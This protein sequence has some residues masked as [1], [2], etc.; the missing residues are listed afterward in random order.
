MTLQESMTAYVAY[1]EQNTK[2]LQDAVADMPEK[3]A[4]AKRQAVADYIAANPPVESGPVTI[5][6]VTYESLSTA[7]QE[8]NAQSKRVIGATNAISVHLDDAIKPAGA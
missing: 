8:L 1:S 4:L 5:D 2:E 7:L 6:G 3:I